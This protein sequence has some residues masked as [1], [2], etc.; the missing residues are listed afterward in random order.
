MAGEPFTVENPYI[1]KTKDDVVKVVTDAGCHDLIKHSMTCT[2]TWEMAKENRGPSE[3]L[4][5]R[6]SRARVRKAMPANP[7]TTRGTGK[8]NP[9]R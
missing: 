4:T 3:M 9:N 6:A 8:K 1:W 5:A 2:H 7:A